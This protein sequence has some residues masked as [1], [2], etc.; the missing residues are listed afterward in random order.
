MAKPDHITASL[1]RITEQTVQLGQRAPG[2]AELVSTVLM[3]LPRLAASISAGESGRLQAGKFAETLLRHV[4]GL[5]ARLPNEANYVSAVVGE[6]NRL[7]VN[8]GLWSARE[9]EADTAKASG[10]PR[11]TR[12]GEGVQYTR[13]VGRA[14][15]PILVEGRSTGS[16]EFHVKRPEYDR[17]IKAITKMKSPQ[18]FRFDDLEAEYLKLGGRDQPS[19]PP[20]RVVLRF[21]RS[22]M[23]PI[24]TRQRAR[25]SIKGSP[26]QFSKAADRAWNS[27]SESQPSRSA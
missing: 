14:G 22:L 6:F 13:R 25:Y 9:G 21:L 10:E 16:K 27:L 19:K 11:H 8:G 4:T 3:H 1:D 2:E 5:M 20:L 7:A 23:P 24:L 26:Q 12:T 15:E 17:V 18:G